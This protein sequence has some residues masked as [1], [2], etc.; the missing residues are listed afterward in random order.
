MLVGAIWVSWEYIRFFVDAWQLEKRRR[1]P[2]KVKG[3]RGAD[4]LGLACIL[5]LRQELFSLIR[6]PECQCLAYEIKWRAPIFRLRSH[7]GLL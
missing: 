5:G 1:Y 6:L 4:G 3:L 7:L 2:P